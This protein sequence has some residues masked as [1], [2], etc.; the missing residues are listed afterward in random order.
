V[1]PVINCSF[2]HLCGDDDDDDDDDDDGDG[3][4]DDDANYNIAVMDWSA[5]DDLMKPVIEKWK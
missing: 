2:L 4:D 1:L 5:E 3:D